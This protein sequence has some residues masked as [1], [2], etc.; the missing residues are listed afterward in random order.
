[1]SMRFAVESWAPEYGVAAD[2][3]HLDET[4]GEVDATVEVAEADWQPLT[5]PPTTETPDHVLFVDGVRRIE[6]RIWYHDGDVVR[7][8]VCA[9]V[10]AGSVVCRGPEAVVHQ[11]EVVRGFFARSAP[12]AGPISTRHGTYEYFPCPGDTAD[13]I[14]LGIHEQMTAVEARI[15]ASHD[16]DLVVFDGPLRHRN[17]PKAVGYVKTQQVQ[18]LPDAL[19]V[20]VGRLAAGERTPLFLIGGRG[21][22]F[23]WYVR[24]PGPRS[25]PLSGVVRVELPA[26]GTIAEAAARADAVTLLLQRFASEPHKDPRAPQNLYPIGGLE[27]RL[28]HRLGDQQVMERALRLASQ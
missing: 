3:T 14:Y 15:A 22:R 16:A 7:P 27:Q 6:A 19:Q 20:V 17:D 9:S 13:D 21:N 4:S 12:T 8:G 23:S 11:V 1:M 18:Y 26:V 10:A 5:P 24:L 25:Q 2:S 28:R